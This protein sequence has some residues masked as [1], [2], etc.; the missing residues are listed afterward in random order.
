MEHPF[1][2][3]SEFSPSMIIQT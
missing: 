1:D 3:K 2:L